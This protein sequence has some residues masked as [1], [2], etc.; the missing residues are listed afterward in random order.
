MDIVN[1]DALVLLAFA[2]KGREGCTLSVIMDEL[3]AGEC[4]RHPGGD[5]D[6]RITVSHLIRI[7]S[8]EILPS[9]N[10]DI[11]N[12]LLYAITADGMAEAR[13]AAQTLLAAVPLAQALL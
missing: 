9:K 1:R 11:R 2:G 5:T 6:F 8:I 10:G 7:H 13:K 12:D 4:E 3:K